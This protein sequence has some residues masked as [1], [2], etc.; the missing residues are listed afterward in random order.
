MFE[1]A[2]S[3]V[4]ELLG[5]LPWLLLTLFALWVA[6]RRDNAA[7]VRRLAVAFV[8]KLERATEVQFGAF[9]VK[10]PETVELAASEARDAV[11]TSEELQGGEPAPAPGDIRGLL[12]RGEMGRVGTYPYLMHAA[13]MVTPRTG[14]HTGRYAVRVWL[15]FDGRYGF[16]RSDV[17]QVVYWLDPSFRQRV[18]ATEA[19]AKDF[20]LWLSLFGEFTIIA[21]VERRDGGEPI[22]LS[23]YLDLPGRPPD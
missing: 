23:R 6:L 10:I 15:E 17:K 9:Q 1:R 14:P 22:W 7:L 21:V 5:S 13:K 3:A 4:A 8:Q 19:A 18:I 11:L 16:E 20:E 2:I 12:E